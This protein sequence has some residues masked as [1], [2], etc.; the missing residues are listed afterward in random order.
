MLEWLA[1]CLVVVMLVMIVREIFRKPANFPPGPPVVPLLGSSVAIKLGSTLPHLVFESLGKIYGKIIGFYLFGQP[2]IILRDYDLIHEAFSKTE[3]S[4][5]EQTF[6][7][8]N[9][10]FF[11]G[12]GIIFGQGG[13][14]SLHRRFALQQLHDLG[15]GRP[16]SELLV[17]LE[18][19]ALVRR[20]TASGGDLEVNTTFCMSGCNALLQL[21]AGKRYE[22]DDPVFAQLVNDTDRVMRLASPGNILS[23][24]PWVRHLAPSATGF[25]ALCA[26][27]DTTCSLFG[28]IVE[29]HRR[30]LN[31]GKPRDYVDA[32]LIEME[33]EGAK[34]KDFTKQH[35]EILLMD[36][37]QAGIETINSTLCWAVLLL[38]RHPEVQARLHAELDEL[39]GANS[40]RWSDRQSLPYL[41]ATINEVHRFG[42]VTNVSVPHFTSFQPV[43]FN[44]YVIPRN[45]LI[46]PDIYHVHHDPSYWSEPER[47][48]P[49]RFIDQN[50]QLVHEPR[51]L[52]FGTGRRSC[53]GESLARMEVFLFVGGLLQAFHLELPPDAPPADLSPQAGVTYKP[54]PFRLRFR[55][56]RPAAP[57]LNVAALALRSEQNSYCIKRSSFSSKVHFK[58]EREI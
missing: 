21:V 52:M 56:R 58:E 47:F 24:L 10:S 31:A 7:I 30:T 17:Q 49:D 44:D 12:N 15:V 55:P 48:R 6:V 43:V 1:A 42:T 20:L 40:L 35:L 32:F 50:G 13:G 5:R 29:E 23:L 11:M 2:V 4:G 46:L 33:K 8:Q 16:R 34:E 41:Q 45:S 39:L 18:V 51:L 9:R 37:F 14:W 36:F 27:R 28:E 57:E 3:F 22:L 53:L 25:R 38:A 26:L 54:R 19:D